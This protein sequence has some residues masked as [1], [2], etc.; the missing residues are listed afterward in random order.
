MTDKDEADVRFGLSLGVDFVALSFV[1][2]AE[3]VVRLRGVMGES[4]RDV[5]IL[6]KIEKAEALENL[7]AILD[8]ADGAM[9]ARGDLGVELPLEEIPGAQ[10]KIIRACNRRGKPVIT[11][12]QMLDSMIRNP[13]PTRAEVTDVANAILDGTDALML[14]GET[15][16]GAYPIEAVETMVRVARRTERDMDHDALLKEK[17]QLFGRESLTD[18]VADAVATIARDQSA[19]AILCA[20]TSGSTAR[21]MA[22][23]R[24]GIPILATTTDE[25]VLRRLALLWG[26]ATLRVPRPGS[27]DELLQKTVEAAVAA[28]CVREGD[29]VVLMSG[30]PVGVSGTTNLIKVHRVGQPL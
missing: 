12:T 4:A 23:F 22:K 24:P 10:K 17:Q 19:A 30:T 27:V 8:E 21:A 5:P 16:V 14:S 3:D 26:V 25:R 7:D 28:G 6:V 20:T 2:S 13:R 9:V 18:A 15:A 1:R 29:L 11:A